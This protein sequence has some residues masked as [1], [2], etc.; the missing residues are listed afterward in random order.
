M[1]VVGALLF[2]WVII[3]SAVISIMAT[4]AATSLIR[5]NGFTD[6]DVTN[7][8]MAAVCVFAVVLVIVLLLL[9]G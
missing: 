7:L 8:A 3:T 9:R 2:I 4:M 5:K 6:V 1:N